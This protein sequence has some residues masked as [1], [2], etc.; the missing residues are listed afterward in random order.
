V[1]VN[2]AA[3]KGAF[4][5][6][7]RR[8]VTDLPADLWRRMLDVNVMGPFLCSQACARPMQTQGRGSIINITSA[9]ASQYREQESLYGASKATVNAM[10]RIMAAQL[11]SANIAVNAINPGQTRTEQTNVDALSE[12]Q[13]ATILRTDTSLPLTL[14]LAEQDPIEVTG[15]V[16]DV[17]EWNQAH[18][19]G[20]RE[21]WA[22]AAGQR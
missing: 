6:A 5:P 19:L 11:K 18:G 17:I 20:G 1:L 22:V 3:L 7:D 12:Q 8:S 2:N 21:A 9:A 13:R 14:F 16:L 4:F 15:E 10:T